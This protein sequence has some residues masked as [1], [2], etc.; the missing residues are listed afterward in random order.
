MNEPRPNLPSPAIFPS[1]IF[2]LV[3]L[4]NGRVYPLHRG[5]NTIGRSDKSHIILESQAVSRR[6]AVLM[7]HDDGT[8]EIGD[9][10]SRAGVFLNGTR[11][12]PIARLTFGD[13]IQ[14]CDVRLMFA[15]DRASSAAPMFFTDETLGAVFWNTT[16]R[17]WHFWVTFGPDR[18]VPATYSPPE[19]TPSASSP[20][21]NLV[22]ASLRQ[23]QAHEADVREVVRKSGNPVGMDPL[24]P[25]QHILFK[26]PIA[27]FVFGDSFSACCVS[28]DQAGKLFGV[29]WISP[30]SFNE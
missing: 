26:P 10:D 18:V 6:H 17:C 28:I 8:C 4:H 13:Q 24:T 3:D 16:D 11:L 30:A 12:C 19:A 29:S 14:I 20:S 21:W 25:L 9:A 2:A 7:V 1:G 27:T 5:R 15:C 22:K 23:V